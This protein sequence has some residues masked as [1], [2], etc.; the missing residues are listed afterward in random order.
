MNAIDGAG[1]KFLMPARMATGIKK[2]LAEYKREIR[3]KRPRT[4]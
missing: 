4:Q 2:A 3:D 1:E